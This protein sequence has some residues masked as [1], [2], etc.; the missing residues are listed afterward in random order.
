MPTQSA[1]LWPVPV[2]LVATIASELTR[3]G[4]SVQQLL[5]GTAISEQDILTPEMLLPYRTVQK[6]LTRACQLSPIP[7]L[8]LAVGARQTPSSMGVCA[9]NF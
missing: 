8:G 5:S 7:H 3:H 6:I 1:E 2:Q 4:I 9:P